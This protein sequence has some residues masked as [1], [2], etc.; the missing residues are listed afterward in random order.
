MKIV[1][2]T[3]MQALDRRTIMEARVSSLVLMERAGAGS[4]EFIQSRFGPLRGKHVTVLCGKGNN[5]GDGLVIARL[6]RQ[7]QANVRVI[8]FARAT[9]LSPDAKVMYRRWVKAGGASRTE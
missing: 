3:Q 6:L 5:G 8:L 7:H 2:G 9:E 4:A 1:T